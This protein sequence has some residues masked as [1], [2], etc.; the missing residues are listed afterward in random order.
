MRHSS[1]NRTNKIP[2]INNFKFKWGGKKKNK[3]LSH[4]HIS[5]KDNISKVLY[6]NLKNRDNHEFKG[7]ME[8]FQR[9][10]ALVAEQAFIRRKWVRVAGGA[11]ISKDI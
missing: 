8:N 10:I 2:E 9:E 3:S 6:W 4:T 11:A 7:T 5:H 1:G